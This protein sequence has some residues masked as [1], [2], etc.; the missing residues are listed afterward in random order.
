M[1]NRRLVV[2]DTET[3]GLYVESGDRVIELACVEIEDFATLQTRFHRYLNPEREIDQEAVRIHGRTWAD[4]KNEPKFAEIAE[5][6]LDVIK[7]AD[8]VMHQAEFDSKFLDSEL[9]RAG[10]D[11]RLQDLCNVVD[12]LAIAREKYRGAHNDLNSLC[13]RFKV[14]LSNRDL[15]GALV[16][17]ELL[18]RV[19]IRM[20][21][22]EQE[23]F[24]IE[25]D[26]TLNTT[27]VRL[28]ASIPVQREPVVV[29]ATDEELAA[30]DAYMHRITG[31][32]G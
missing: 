20:V 15:H 12:S 28:G 22:G 6:F 14:D 7:N 4:L 24:D 23:L 18:A 32:S 11:V 31:N 13:K 19:Y 2:V 1:T 25:D 17:A 5:E 9:E 16:D 27:P 10:V 21:S 8:V 30:H 26:K 3:T 29:H